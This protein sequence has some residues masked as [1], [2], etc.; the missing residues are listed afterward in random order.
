MPT[1]R[2]F[3]Y[4]EKTKS[5]ACIAKGHSTG[6]MNLSDDAAHINE[7]FGQA[8]ECPA[9]IEKTRYVLKMEHELPDGAKVFFEE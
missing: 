4:D 9:D 1:S 6:W 2:L 8:E 3:I 5:A 7:F